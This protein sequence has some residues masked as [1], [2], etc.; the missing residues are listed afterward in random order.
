[1]RSALSDILADGETETLKLVAHTQPHQMERGPLAEGTPP[2][3]AS[4]C[5]LLCDF[6]LG[7]QLSED[8][9]TE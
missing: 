5:L 3:S 6:P 8:L 2:I 4:Q 9:L 7:P 1:M